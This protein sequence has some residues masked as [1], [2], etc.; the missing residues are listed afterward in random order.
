MVVLSGGLSNLNRGH[1]Q[2]LISNKDHK[3]RR[4]RT[5]SRGAWP[6]GR[7]RYGQVAGAIV[8]V[9][10]QARG[11]LSI[12]TIREQV[13]QLLGGPVSRHSISDYLCVR[14]KGPSPLFERSRLGHYRLLR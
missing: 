2:S 11:E 14:S 12:R 9:L 5:T 13:E 4:K 8:D 7:R 3:I 6:D 10:D 1:F